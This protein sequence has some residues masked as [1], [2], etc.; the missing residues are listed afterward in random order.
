MYLP[1]LGHFFEED[2]LTSHDLTVDVNPIQKKER[3]K[4]RKKCTTGDT[5]SHDTF[6]R[7]IST[8]G[9]NNRRH[10]FR[11]THSKG[12]I[13]TRDQFSFSEEDGTTRQSQSKILYY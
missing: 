5:F 1:V 10:I 11:M 4:K 2:E 6:K 12:R 8:C 9:Q 3:R 7:R 13:S